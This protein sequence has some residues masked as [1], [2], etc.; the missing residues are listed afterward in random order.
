M[1]LM[2]KLYNLLGTV[3]ER[4]SDNGYEKRSAKAEKR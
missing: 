4:K 2:F 3:D 1:I